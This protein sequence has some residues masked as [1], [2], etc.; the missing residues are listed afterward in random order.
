M[1]KAKEDL[2]IAKDMGVDIVGAFPYI[3]QSIENCE[4]IIGIKLPEEIAAL[5]MQP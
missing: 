3:Y 1:G 5:L 2:T 4:Q